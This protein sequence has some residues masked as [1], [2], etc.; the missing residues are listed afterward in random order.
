MARYYQ[1]ADPQLIDNFIYTPPYELMLQV[2]NQK[3]AQY[4]Q[5]IAS[6]KLLGDVKIDYL[7]GEYDA[8]NVQEKQRYYND[9]ANSIIEGIRKDPLNVN[10]YIGEI[11]N[12]QKEIKTDFTSGEI[13]K[14]VGSKAAFTKWEEENKKMMEEEPARY[15]AIKNGLLTS[16]GGNSLKNQWKGEAVTKDVDW[17]KVYDSASK[18]IADEYETESS[19]VN[20]AYIYKNKQSG[21]QVSYKD[22]MD[23]ILGRTLTP[24]NKAA[25]AQ[26]QIFGIANYFKDD[27]SIDIDYDEKGNVISS[28]SGWVPSRLV[29]SSAAFKE[30]KQSNDIQ[31]NSVWTTMYSQNEANKAHAATLK[32]TNYWKGVERADKLKELSTKGQLTE[33]D[34]FELRMDIIEETDPKIK[35]LKQQEYN[36]ITGTQFNTAVDKKVLYKDIYGTTAVKGVSGVGNVV[37]EARSTARKGI[38]TEDRKLAIFIDA[39]IANGKIKK[40]EDIQK[41]VGIYVRTNKL[42]EQNVKSSVLYNSLPSKNNAK[43]GQSMT[44]EY[45]IESSNNNLTKKYTN[46]AKNYI[47][48]QN[49]FISNYA[50]QASSQKA[51]EVTSV[52][53][54]NQGA[55][56]IKRNPTDFIMTFKNEKGQNVTAPL[57]SQQDVKIK[58]VTS[59]QSY[60]PLGIAATVGGKDVY[61]LPSAEGIG[62]VSVQTLQKVLSN[63]LKADSR[64][65]NSLQ[66]NTLNELQQLESR[67]GISERGNTIFTYKTGGK[68][69]RVNKTNGIYIPVDEFANPILPDNVR[70]TQLAELAKYI[71][72]K[73]NK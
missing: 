58:A 55:E 11:D 9:R 37:G 68:E 20:G 42:G 23:N 19:G 1:T 67:A 40:E 57:S 7:N 38:S 63:G 41:Y 69:F 47:D 54:S 29:A 3:Q 53:S 33:K 24:E 21:K 22:I 18:I 73:N 43:P 25:L 36:N 10:G 16:W 71:D 45:H 35:D 27:G 48:K 2:A 6:A 13:S 61:I 70:I 60:G 15:Q 8:A 46:F 62:G 12:L 59:G 4:D 34:L 49:N 50:N 14:F 52:N 65:R 31:T 17:Q 64:V 5:A 72:L 51:F 66:N 44:K 30:S 56:I 26:S 28:S 39:N 32:Y